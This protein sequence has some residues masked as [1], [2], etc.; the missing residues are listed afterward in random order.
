[1][2]ALPT[3]CFEPVRP[4]TAGELPQPE[5]ALADGMAAAR[6]A[7][8]AAGRRAARAALVA[9]GWASGAI[10][11]DPEGAPLLLGSVRDA[12]PCI[13]ISH[14]GAMAVAAVHGGRCAVDLELP[15]RIVPELWPILFCA[16]EARAWRA[17]PPLAAAAA[18]GYKECVQ[19]LLTRAQVPPHFELSDIRVELDDALRLSG[20]WVL[21]Q[22]W[23][24]WC[25][26]AQPLRFDGVDQ[27]HLLTALYR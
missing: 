15:E 10:L 26:L 22:R 24:G 7:Q 20:L 8:F 11:P 12:A 14:T 4:A 18:F 1:M 17:G 3:L 23:D 25:S 5:R 27:E 19:K 21:G 16:A 13:S 9:A 6:L 2:N